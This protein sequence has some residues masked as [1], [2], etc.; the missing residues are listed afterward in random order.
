VVNPEPMPSC[1][2]GG[3]YHCFN[4]L[5]VSSFMSIVDFLGGYA[6]KIP[7]LSWQAHSDMS[8]VHL[9]VWYLSDTS[10][11]YEIFYYLKYGLTCIYVD[12]WLHRAASSSLP[13]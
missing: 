9:C 8:Q 10:M 4:F 3:I 1:C 6:T 7:E 13:Q 2:A 5:F 12:T 11:A